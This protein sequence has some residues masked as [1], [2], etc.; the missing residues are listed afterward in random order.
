[1][2]KSSLPELVLSFAN[3]SGAARKLVS[4]HVQQ[5]LFSLGYFW[6]AGTNRGDWVQGT[7][8][9]T[10]A[11]SLHVQS[12]EW[13]PRHITYRSAPTTVN[14]Q[15]PRSTFDAAHEVDGFLAEAKRRVETRKTE[16]NGVL[17]DISKDGVKLDAT[18]LLA[19]VAREAEA[20]RKEIWGS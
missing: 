3:L 8:Q 18:N 4:T 19:E 16:I 17:V 7:A 9:Y 11:L 20:M 10:D 15:T 5:V 12:P 2:T 14:D 13:N 6:T 1:M